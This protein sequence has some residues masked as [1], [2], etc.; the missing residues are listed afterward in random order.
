MADD[1][2]SP[3]D[4]ERRWAAIARAIIDDGDYMTLAT[5]DESGRPWA[6][7]VWYSGQGAYIEGVADQVP[8][9]ELERCV[10]AYSQPSQ[11]RGAGAL[12]LAEVCEPA[13]HRLY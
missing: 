5:A 7:P 13:P 2:V 12:T 4:D 3:L 9:S 10:A 6:S 11:A 8:E 1:R